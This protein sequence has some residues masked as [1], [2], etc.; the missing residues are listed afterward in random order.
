MDLNDF[1]ALCTCMCGESENDPVS[2]WLAFY[3]CGELSGAS[4]GHKH[5]QIIPP[6]YVDAQGVARQYFSCSVVPEAL[7]KRLERVPCFHFKHA[8]GSFPKRHPNETT[9]ELAQ[10][11]LSMYHLL[12]TKLGLIYNRLR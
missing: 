1:I 5:L 8:I 3:N 6:S 9:K 4:Q 2:P 12:L 11:W 10:R 7:E